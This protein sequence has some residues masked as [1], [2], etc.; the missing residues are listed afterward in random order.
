MSSGPGVGD[1]VTSVDGRHGIITGIEDDVVV[2]ETDA[3]E[4]VSVAMEELLVERPFLTF[5]CDKERDGCGTLVHLM[6]SLAIGQAA[7][8]ECENCGMSWTVVHP[9]LEVYRTDAYEA[10]WPF[11]GQ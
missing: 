10:K 1:V 5:P 4:L 9:S 11:V 7:V 3:G 6:E 8:L 2:V